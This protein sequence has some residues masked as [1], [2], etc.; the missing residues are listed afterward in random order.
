M[1]RFRV[2]VYFG[3]NSPLRCSSVGEVVEPDVDCEDDERAWSWV[4]E[5]FGD[6]EVESSDGLP[7]DGEPRAGTTTSTSVTSS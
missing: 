1:R 7:G 5:V 2:R 4:E 6:E 3:S